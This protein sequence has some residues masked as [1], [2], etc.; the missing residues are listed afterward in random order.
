MKCKFCN[1]ELAEGQK[2]CSYCGNKVEPEVTPVVQ[3]AQA[4][5]PAVEPAP[6]E[7]V[8]EAPVA[9]TQPVAVPQPAP[10][11]APVAQ[12]VSTPTA[13]PTAEATTEQDPNEKSALIGFIMGI[14]SFVVCCLGLPLGIV[15]IIF[16]V[17]GLKS[18]KKGFA[19]PGI[20]LS[21]VGLINFFS[22]WFSFIIGFFQG[23]A[24]M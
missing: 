22:F 14:A 8:V 7:I 17:R 6:A 5:A 19:I 11:P 10:T 21:A 9:K 16:S 18:A 24:G 3:E 2:F 12:F 23:M 4:E 15:G 13:A 1:A 20:I